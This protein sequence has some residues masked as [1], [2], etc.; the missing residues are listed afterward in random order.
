MKRKRYVA[1]KMVGGYYGDDGYYW[2]VVDVVQERNVRKNLS[3]FDA[4]CEA[5]SLNKSLEVES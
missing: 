3:R 2:K 1:K 5:D 4:R